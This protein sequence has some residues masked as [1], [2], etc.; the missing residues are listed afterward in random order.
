MFFYVAMPS[1][2]SKVAP[3]LISFLVGAIAGAVIWPLQKKKRSKVRTRQDAINILTNGGK[4]N[5]GLSSVENAI[6]LLEATLKTCIDDEARATVL[7]AIDCLKSRPGYSLIPLDLRRSSVIS[8][9]MSPSQTPEEQNVYD[10][11]AASYTQHPSHYS[12]ITFHEVAKLVQRAVRVGRAFNHCLKSHGSYVFD[13]S[14]SEL[15]HINRALEGVDEWDWDIWTLHE[16]TQG[17]PL[18]ALGW[19]LLHKYDLIKDLGL[20]WQVVKNWLHFV[21]GLYQDTP[22]HNS[23]HAADVLQAVHHLLCKAGALGMLNPLTAFSLLVAA[24]MHDAGHDGLSNA[25]HQ[26]AATDRAL[27]F[28]DQSIQENFHLSTVFAHMAADPAL[29]L[30]AALGPQ[31]AREV[32]RLAILAILATDMKGH[33]QHVHEFRSAVDANPPPPA[34]TG[35]ANSWQSDPAL[36]DL[37]CA[38]LLH[39]ADLSNP[40]RPY[41]LSRRWSVLVTDEFFAQG[42]RERRLGLPVSPMCAREATPL[43]ASQAP[44]PARPHSPGRA[45]MP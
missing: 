37:L 29:N 7:Y 5:R 30:L 14:E 39:A 45:H 23:T 13:V 19:H 9:A 25:F 6:S 3:I 41:P 31:R 8:A 16:A 12:G 22:Y 11:L 17:R 4:F 33:F 44:A 27:A 42:D 2:V 10:W 38:N 36:A 35:S 21:A 40:C 1:S 24:M 34:A 15:D 26:S 20:D 28:N 43:A 32:R 18:Q